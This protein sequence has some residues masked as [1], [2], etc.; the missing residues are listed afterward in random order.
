M[1]LFLATR[2]VQ[3][4]AQI[5]LLIPSNPALKRMLN[6][7]LHEEQAAS[8]GHFKKPGELLSTYPNTQVR[9]QW[10]PMKVPFIGFLTAR[11]LTFEAIHTAVPTGQHKPPSIKKQKEVTKRTA[12]AKWEDRYYNNPRSSLAFQTA[13]RSPPDGRT[14]HTFNIKPTPQG[15][16]RGA[17][18]DE[19]ARDQEATT[20]QKRYEHWKGLYRIKTFTSLVKDIKTI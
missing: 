3:Q 13:L 4:H 18:P 7:S 11:Q 19:H 12:I 6:A 9:L 5:I 14:H 20:S 15:G 17:E 10:L 1:A 2:P 16:H 8:I